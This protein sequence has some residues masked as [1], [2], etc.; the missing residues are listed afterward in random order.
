MQFEKT[1]PVFISNK[2]IIFINALFTL[3]F[4][5]EPL[6]I[7]SGAHVIRKKRSA[8]LCLAINRCTLQPYQFERILGG[9]MI[10]KLFSP[11]VLLATC[12]VFILAAP[13]P[14]QAQNLD[15][16]NI[17]ILPESDDWNYPGRFR[18][19][20]LA[21]ATVSWEIKCT[22]GDCEGRE[23]EFVFDHEFSQGDIIF[24]GW[25]H[26]CYQVAIRSH[27]LAARLYC[28]TRMF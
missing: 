15:W 17:E 20:A 22:V 12:L 16:G 26:Q 10:K 27:R 28:R 3:H 13:S 8:Q 21:D 14:A 4:E 18:L 6:F 2:G 11:A 9:V 1:Q 5:G 24:V 7:S 19:R 25:G 23:A